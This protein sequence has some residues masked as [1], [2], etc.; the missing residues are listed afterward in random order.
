MKQNY[1]FFYCC[2]FLLGGLLSSC[3]LY[4]PAEPVPAFI[5]IQKITLETDPAIEG[6]NS[7]KITDAWVYIDGKLVGVYELPVTLPVLAEGERNLIIKAGIKINGISATRGPYPFYSSYDQ[8]VTLTPGVITNV[9]PEVGY[10]S[11]IDWSGANIWTEDF[12]GADMS[13][14]T[15]AAGTDTNMYHYTIISGTHPNV[16]EGTGSGIAYLDRTHAK[17]EYMSTTSFVLP[18]GD[19]PTFLELNYKANHVFVVGVFSHGPAGTYQNRVINVNPSAEWN[20]IYIYMSPVVNAAA[21]STDHTVFIGMLNTTGQD[22][23]YLAV[24]NIKLV[25]F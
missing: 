4:N 10:V 24:D 6:S 2:I 25:H 14:D 23:V 8:R 9:N 17:F 19:S 16:F 21:G 1:S 5:H 20:K 15:S 7:S 12:D 13:L 22:G 11:G 3:N 18:R